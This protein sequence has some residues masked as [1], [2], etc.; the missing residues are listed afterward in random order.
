M[1]N[2]NQS[3]I[4]LP[5]NPKWLKDHILFLTR[6]GSH[7]YGTNIE[8]S[9]ED[10]RG[11][12]SLPS[13]IVFGFIEKFEQAR[14]S[15][16][17]DIE[18][19]SI[20]KF[21]DLAVKNNPNILE[22]L[23]VDDSSIV[24]TTEKWERLRAVRQKFLSKRIASTFA[25]YAKS[26]LH[27]IRTHRNY[28]LNP[29]KSIPTREEFGLPARSLIPKLHAADAA[30]Q[31]QL[32][33]IAGEWSIDKVQQLEMYGEVCKSLGFNSNFV[34]LLHREKRYA[35][36]KSEQEAYNN[37]AKQRNPKRRA[38]EEKCGYDSKHLMHLVRLYR[39]CLECLE[40]GT[41]EIKRHDAQELIEIRQG[42]WPFD[43]IEAWA[44]DAESLIQKALQTT[45][46]PSRPDFNT[47][48]DIVQ[49]IVK[50]SV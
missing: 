45:K 38:L 34:E 26:Q 20:I 8:G 37:W 22:L 2:T 5:D 4:K 7:A 43:K 42:S 19:Y 11:V 28:L 41:L 17:Q 29:V 46:L 39:E 14:A 30:V 31:K 32:D 50:E 10:F 27:R 23:F 48:N 25:G 36:L 44:S 24:T 35:A 13:H 1:D 49:S 33:A 40:T 9:D 15:E 3:L 12:C 18:I 16:P 21:A 6:A 47:I